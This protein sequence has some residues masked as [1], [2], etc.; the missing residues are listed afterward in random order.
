[1]NHLMLWSTAILLLL[2]TTHPDSGKLQSF[3]DQRDGKEYKVTRIGKL[4]IMAENLAYEVDDAY[5]Y[6][7]E[8][9][10]CQHY[11]K[12]YDY[13]TA[14]GDEK[15]GAVRGIC[16]QGWHIPSEEEWLYILSGLRGKAT[17]KRNNYISFLVPN[18]L[19]RMRFSG[20]K[21]HQENRFYQLGQRGFYM[22]SGTKDGLWTAVEI[23]R[24]G[25][26]DFMALHS[27]TPIKRAISCRCIQDY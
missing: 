25:E 16:P 12:L 11:G 13:Q 18:N 5:C 27:K 20:F 8:S 1:M 24:N 10:F 9:H 7:N 17:A 2:G 14:V 21:S 19:L 22:A 6:Q 23:K 26:K 15:G 3:K 4:A